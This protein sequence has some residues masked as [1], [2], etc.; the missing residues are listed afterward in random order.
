MLF[1]K[2]VIVCVLYVKIVINSPVSPWTTWLPLLFVVIITGAKQGYEDFLRHVRDREVNLQNIDVIRNGTIRV[3]LE[4]FKN[5]MT[6]TSI[7][8]TAKNL[9]LHFLEN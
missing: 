8:S 9:E 1:A 7:F 6:K 4:A 2:F 3:L 5:K